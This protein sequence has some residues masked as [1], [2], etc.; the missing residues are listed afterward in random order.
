[1]RWYRGAVGSGTGG[2][3]MSIVMG[4]YRWEDVFF[5]WHQRKYIVA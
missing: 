5:S 2:I 4:A 1:M 3:G